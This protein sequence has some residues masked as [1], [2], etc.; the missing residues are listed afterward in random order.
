[1]QLTMF[2]QIGKKGGSVCSDAKAEAARL[3]G[4]KGG[5]PRKN[6]E[7]AW[8]KIAAMSA[9]LPAAG[10]EILNQSG[11]TYEIDSKW[12]I[13]DDCETRFTL[14]PKAAGWEKCEFSDGWDCPACV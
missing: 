13:C 11:V 3:N 12:T 4:K 8:K 9:S 2:Q 14:D 6:A 5:R 7:P 1:M 10:V